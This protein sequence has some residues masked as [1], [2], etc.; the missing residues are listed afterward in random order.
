MEYI[1]KFY[2]LPWEYKGNYFFVQFKGRNFL[3]LLG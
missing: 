3:L 1:S 2:L